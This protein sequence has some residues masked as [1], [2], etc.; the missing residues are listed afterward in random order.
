MVIGPPIRELDSPPTTREE[1][2]RIVADGPDL[3]ADLRRALDQLGT[4]IARTPP[5]DAALPTPCASW[6]VRAL[7]G[8]VLLDVERFTATAR[9]EPWED[10]ETGVDDGRWTESYRR[11]ADGLRA[12]WERE[13][14]L[15]RTVKSPSGEVPVTW[16]IG[17]QIA[18]LVVHAWDLAKATGQSTALDPELGEMAL[19][20]GRRNLRPEFR[21]AEGSGKSFGPEVRVPDDAPVY[22]RLAA[23]FGRTPS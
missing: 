3:V 9:D 18:D 14:A 17:L 4:V 6:D 5:E 10:H 20:W 2:T 19:D 23:F 21:G 15:D 13:G 8:H 11:A 12:A 22:D 7:I 1:A 16:S